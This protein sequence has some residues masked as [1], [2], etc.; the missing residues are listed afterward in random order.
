MA[1]FIQQLI[2]KSQKELYMIVAKSLSYC[3]FSFGH[4]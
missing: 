3:D 2:N 1:I 4:N